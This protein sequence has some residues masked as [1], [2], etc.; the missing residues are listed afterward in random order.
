MNLG[1]LSNQGGGSAGWRWQSSL[2]FFLIHAPN[3]FVRLKEAPKLPYITHF[4]N[5]LTL[6]SVE[7]TSHLIF[8]KIYLT[9]SLCFFGFHGQK[10]QNKLQNL[11]HTILDNPINK[12][13]HQK[14]R[15]K[16][17]RQSK[18]G[19][20]SG[21]SLTALK[22]SMFFLNLPLYFSYGNNFWL[23]ISH[24]CQREDNKYFLFHFKKR[25]K[26]MLI[27]N[28]HSREMECKKINN[29]FHSRVREGTS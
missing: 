11:F 7:V 16:K 13:H 14:E 25:R 9:D 19:Q 17:L 22:D 3:L 21:V 12:K 26:L 6:Y 29:N 18:I 27:Y 8:V 23:L 20:G 5:S 4:Q 1:P 10:K 28:F 2:G 24:L 15:K